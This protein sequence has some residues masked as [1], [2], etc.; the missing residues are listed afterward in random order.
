[1]KKEFFGSLQ[2]VFCLLWGLNFNAN[3]CMWYTNFVTF[4]IQMNVNSFLSL[5]K[6]Y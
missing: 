3:A 2:T 6:Q 4:L 5:E 1:M